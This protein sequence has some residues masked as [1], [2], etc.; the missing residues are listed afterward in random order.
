MWKRLTR[1]PLETHHA[2][3]FRR[4]M[5]TVSQ[6]RQPSCERRHFVDARTVKSRRPNNWG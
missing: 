1:V 6:G 5:V 4:P 2:A 3:Q